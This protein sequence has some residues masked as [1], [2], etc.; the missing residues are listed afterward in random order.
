MCRSDRTVQQVKRNLATQL[1]FA[2]AGGSVKEGQVAALS[3]RLGLHARRPRARSRIGRRSL[4]LPARLSPMSFG[5]NGTSRSSSGGGG[6]SGSAVCL[7]HLGCSSRRMPCLLS[8]GTF[9]T[10]TLTIRSRACRPARG[11]GRWCDPF[12]P[13]RHSKAMRREQ[14]MAA[15]IWARGAKQVG[16]AH[17]NWS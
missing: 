15:M 11:M 10:P 4:P 7:S 9:R 17:S 13:L 8:L 2:L 5:Q 3:T 14:H 12:S 6:C 16:L 1:I